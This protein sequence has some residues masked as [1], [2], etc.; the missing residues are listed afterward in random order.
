[1]VNMFSIFGA[2]AKT[3]YKSWCLFLRLV[4]AKFAMTTLRQFFVS[5]ML[6]STCSTSAEVQEM[7]VFGCH[8]RETGAPSHCISWSSN[9]FQTVGICVVYVGDLPPN[10]LM[11][12]E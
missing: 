8:E 5:K 1:M 11:V 2:V 9:P 4:S 3:N 10:K 12:S 6:K 7:V